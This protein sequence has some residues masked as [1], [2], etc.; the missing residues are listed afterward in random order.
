MNDKK[1]AYIDK[2]GIM[3]VTVS[4]KTA[5]EY[6]K[7]GTGV[8]ETDIPSRFGYPLAQLG[9]DEVGIIVYSPVLM[10]INAK[11]KA[12]EVI[13]ELAEIYQKNN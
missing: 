7:R 2:A 5:E 6:H 3:H 13:P 4:L 10:K 8:V 1:Y 12:I 11:G 9:D